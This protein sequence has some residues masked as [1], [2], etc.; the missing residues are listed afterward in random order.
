VAQRGTSSTSVTTGGYYSVDRW[1]T[2]VNALG[3]WTI[4][5]DSTGPVGFSTSIKALCTTADASPA[6]GD[7]M[8]IQ[9]RIE[10]QNL[11]SL[12]FGTSGAKNMTLSFWVKSNKTG[13]GSI[14]IINNDNSD[15]SAYPSYTINSADTWEYKTVTISGDTT[16]GPA[17]DNGTGF[18]VAF[19]LNSGSNF[20]GGSHTTSFGTFTNANRNASNLGV[21]G[22]TNDYWQI[23]GVQ[24]EVGTEAT[25]FEHRSFGDELIR[26]QRYFQK[27]LADTSA[28]S[29]CT[30][31]MI[32]D[33]GF[34]GEYYFSNTMRAT[35]SLSQSGTYKV[36]LKTN[37]RA[38][39]SISINRGTTDQVQLFS[40]LSSDNN[41]IGLPGFI[42][43]DNSGDF[44][45][46]DAEL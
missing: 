25:P 22:A 23:T 4:S 29:I 10:A 39:G 2:A 32:S 42:K 3:T 37:D 31:A 36:R 19:W 9:Q 34:I 15:R 6:S 17:N 43:V 30:G 26:C 41:E 20:T 33:T 45:E 28:D 35:P 16:G 11:Q 5:Q 21:G 40:S 38:T 46:F 27:W 13:S 18:E 1:R 7:Y 24:L 44:L 14:E 8:V 12:G